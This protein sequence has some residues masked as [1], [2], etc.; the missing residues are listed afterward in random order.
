MD[1]VHRDVLMGNNNNKGV[2]PHLKDAHPVPRVRLE[3]S[4]EGVAAGD[5]G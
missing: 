1:K 5:V 2:F 3:G 4:V